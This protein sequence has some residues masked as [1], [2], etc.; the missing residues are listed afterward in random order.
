MGVSRSGHGR[1]K[2]QVGRPLPNPAPMIQL[3]AAS[4]RREPRI[5]WASYP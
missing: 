5:M 4:G 2:T 1:L 3:K